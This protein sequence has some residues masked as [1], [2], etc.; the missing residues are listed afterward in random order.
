LA[1]RIGSYQT[2]IFFLINEANLIV[3][4]LHCFKITGKSQDSIDENKQREKGYFIIVQGNQRKK[5]A[6]LL[7][8]SVILSKYLVELYYFNFTNEQEKSYIVF[9]A[10]F[11]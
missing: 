8:L 6:S 11:D 2:C 10:L 4:F 5:N 3:T 1:Y 9:Q 7:L